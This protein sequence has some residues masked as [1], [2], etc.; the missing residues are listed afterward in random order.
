VCHLTLGVSRPSGQLRMLEARGG[1]A[2]VSLVAV[3]GPREGVMRTLSLA[4]SS[5]TGLHDK[6][7]EGSS[8]S[9]RVQREA[10]KGPA[11]Q[12]DVGKDSHG[13]F[14]EVQIGASLVVENAWLPFLQACEAAQ[15]SEL[16]CQGLERGL[17]GV[18]HDRFSAEQGSSAGKPPCR[19][20]RGLTSEVRPATAWV[21]EL[22]ALGCRLD[23][24]VRLRVAVAAHCS[25]AVHRG[26]SRCW[27][28]RSCAPSPKR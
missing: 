25:R 18:L 10:L 24:P 19:S 11:M 16:S 1:L 7:Q 6:C 17:A 28:H 26:T 21:H 4:S 13:V 3:T 22:H 14:M 5:R 20:M 23:R 27:H 12:F 2:S 9:R 8:L 15:N